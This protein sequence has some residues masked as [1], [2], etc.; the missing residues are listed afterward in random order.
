MCVSP[1]PSQPTWAAGSAVLPVLWCM[2]L[3][4]PCLFMPLSAPWCCR[5]CVPLSC[6]LPGGF[7]P[8]GWGQLCTHRGDAGMTLILCSAEPSPAFSQPWGCV[9]HVCISCA[10][11]FK[12]IHSFAFS[13][14]PPFPAKAVFITSA[15]KLLTRVCGG[16]RIKPPLISL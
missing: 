16:A 9:G 8:Q 12:A 2:V 7:L 4:P 14:I 10:S 13:S 6:S 5:P 11:S 3:F 1:G 15:N